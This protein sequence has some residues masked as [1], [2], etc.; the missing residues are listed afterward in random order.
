MEYKEEENMK[1]YDIY[2]ETDHATKTGYS[3]FVQAFDENDAVQIMRDQVMYNDPEDLS[4]IKAVTEITE[5]E[6]MKG[7]EGKEP[8]MPNTIPVTNIYFTNDK[9]YE[10]ETQFDTQ[11]E[12]EL[13]E[14]WWSFCKESK[15]HQCGERNCRL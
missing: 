9:G 7:V 5:E 6:Y 2:I 14:L 8:E 4:C 3:V 10:D 1:Y 15:T 13:A 12:S 11:D